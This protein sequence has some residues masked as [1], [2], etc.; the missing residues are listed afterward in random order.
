MNINATLIMQLIHFFV[1]YGIV[2]WVLLRPIYQIILDKRHKEVVINN[3]IAHFLSQIELQKCERMKAWQLCR[4]FYE[5]RSAMRS[6]G[7][8]Q[9]LV[10]KTTVGEDVFLDY[11]DQHQEL[12]EVVTRD[13]FERITRDTV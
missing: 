12:V 6:K 2:R 10:Q 5:E 8:E 9:P 13:L 3:R 4:S 7:V 1:A 11:T